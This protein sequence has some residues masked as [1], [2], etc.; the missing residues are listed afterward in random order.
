MTSLKELK[1]R[2]RAFLADPEQ[3]QDF[4]SWFALVLRDAHLSKDP[5]VGELAHE[6]MWAF[7]DQRRGMTTPAELASTLASLATPTP[8]VHFELPESVTTGTST[9]DLQ[10]A[11]GFDLG[12]LQVDVRCASGRA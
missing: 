7:D 3:E 4:R 8:E 1:E 2:L 9:T 12:V 5:A 6:V 11:R 10:T